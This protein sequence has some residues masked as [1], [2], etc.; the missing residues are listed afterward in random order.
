MWYIFTME[1]S[2][3]IKKNEI[4]PFAATWMQLE[5]LIRRGV[6]YKDKYRTIITYMQDLKYGTK[7][8][9]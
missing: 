7:E 2:S 8:H 9:I 6:G 3:A 4:T 5:I 1:Y